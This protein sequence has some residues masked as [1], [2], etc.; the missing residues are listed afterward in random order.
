MKKIIASDIARV[1]E[2]DN[3]KALFARMASYDAQEGRLTIS[4]ETYAIVC[5]PEETLLGN[6]IEE[7]LGETDEDWIAFMPDALLQLALAFEPSEDQKPQIT[8]F[9]TDLVAC[10]CRCYFAEM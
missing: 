4:W 5:T 7:L 8:C 6:F 3:S 2:A 1:K 10:L 9:I